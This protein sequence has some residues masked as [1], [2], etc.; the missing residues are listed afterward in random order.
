TEAHKGVPWTKPEDMVV[1]E[2]SLPK[3]GGQFK[4]FINVLFCDGS[5]RRIKLTAKEKA[6]RADITPDGGEAIEEKIS[7]IVPCQSRRT[8]QIREKRGKQR[9]LGVFFC[10]IGIM[11]R[12]GGG[13]P[14]HC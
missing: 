5:V 12:M 3:L 8:G 1:T 6:L 4:G 13:V 7:F 9:L 11:R 14:T 2:K 10:V